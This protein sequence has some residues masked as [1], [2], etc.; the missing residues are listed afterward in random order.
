MSTRPRLGIF[1]SLIALA[2]FSGARI[3]T[4]CD[5]FDQPPCEAFWRASAVFAG[6]VVWPDG[7]PAAG[8]TVISTIDEYEY[9]SPGKTVVADERGRFSINAFE[10]LKYFLHAIISV[11]TAG[12]QM[13][14][15]PV[16]IPASGDVTG[17]KLMLTSPGDVCQRCRHRYSRPK[18]R[19]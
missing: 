9:N 6:T 12:G 10:G 7:R 19:S 11:Q 3:R 1:L 8:A 18:K 16:D 2:H 5:C 13:H 4:S 17:V 14:A 15:D